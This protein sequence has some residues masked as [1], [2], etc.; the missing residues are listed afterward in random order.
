M[1]WRMRPVVT[2]QCG[3]QLRLIDIPFTVSADAPTPGNNQILRSLRHEKCRFYSPVFPGC[4]Y[5]PIGSHKKCGI[6]IQ[7]K[8]SCHITAILYQNDTSSR[9]LAG[10]RRGLE[11][12]RIH[13]SRYRRGAE[14]ADVKHGPFR[15]RL[16]NY[17]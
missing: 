6:V 7:V 12:R 9:S 5:L 11:S 13:P 3:L 16:R 1:S 8:G 2:K 15:R 14:I 17:L 10:V 4:L